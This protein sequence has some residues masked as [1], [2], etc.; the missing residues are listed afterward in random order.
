VSGA[1]PPWLEP[2]H[3]FLLLALL[4]VV[5]AAATVLAV[6]AYRR[7]TLRLART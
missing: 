6:L 7:I 1:V 2:D 4:V 3:L 5:I